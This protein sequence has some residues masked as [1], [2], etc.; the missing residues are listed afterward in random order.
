MLRSSICVP[1]SG[2]SREEAVSLRLTAALRCQGRAGAKCLSLHR[3]TEM[4]KNPSEN[5]SAAVVR[6]QIRLRLDGLPFASARCVPEQSDRN[7]IVTQI[8]QNS[9]D[10]VSPSC[11]WAQRSTHRRQK[12]AGNGVLARSL[13][14]TVKVIN[15]CYRYILK[16]SMYFLKTQAT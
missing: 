11:C 5:F 15:R 7:N 12:L 3:H 4:G 13:G 9:L 8:H 1:R 14:W 16:V 10:K 6:W 2:F